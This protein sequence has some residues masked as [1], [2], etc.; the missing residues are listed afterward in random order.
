LQLCSLLEGDLLE[1][2]QKERGYQMSIR[3]DNIVDFK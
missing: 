2:E 1:H 3:C